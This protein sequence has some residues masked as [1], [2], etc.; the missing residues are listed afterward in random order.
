MSAKEHGEIKILGNCISV[1]RH[2]HQL[3]GL[4]RSMC[5]VGLIEAGREINS[6]VE[7]LEAISSNIREQTNDLI[8]FTAMSINH[9]KTR[10]Q[11]SAQ[12]WQL[13]RK[14]YK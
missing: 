12:P 7:E 13:S 4:A 2:L 3:R 10:M 14:D 9:S 8:R 1:D 6:I 11:S 5:R